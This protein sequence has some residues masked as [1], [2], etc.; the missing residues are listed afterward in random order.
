MA[1]G[2]KA[3]RFSI[4]SSVI[5]GFGL[6]VAIALVLMKVL[7]AVPGHFTISEWVALGIWILLGMAAALTKKFNRHSAE[8]RSISLQ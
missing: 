8:V 7:P 5:A 1:F 3:R 6:A 2:S 4:G